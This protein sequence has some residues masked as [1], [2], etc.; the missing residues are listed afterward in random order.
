LKAFGKGIGMFDF[1]KKRKVDTGVLGTGNGGSF[2]NYRTEVIEAANKQFGETWPY[3]PKS[4]LFN[5]EIG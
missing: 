4:G 3:D 2:E 5:A 1:F